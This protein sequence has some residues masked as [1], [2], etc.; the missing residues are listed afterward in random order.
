MEG[1]EGEAEE[2]EGGILGGAPILV[3]I[4][5]PTEIDGLSAISE[6]LTSSD[7]CGELHGSEARALEKH[8]FHSGRE[9]GKNLGIL[10][11]CALMLSLNPRAH[12]C[13]LW[14]G[15]EPRGCCG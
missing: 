2:E 11:Q 1:R 6:E 15:T 13:V 12:G 3:L 7:V 14:E 10:C 8:W 5:A 4:H 9:W